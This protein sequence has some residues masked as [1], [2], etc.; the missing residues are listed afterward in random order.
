[1]KKINNFTTIDTI[2][3]KWIVSRSAAY[4]AEA[5]IKNG[6][7]IHPELVAFMTP[8]INTLPDNCVIVDAGSN[9][10][11]FS[12]PFAYL[13][14]DRGG[15]VY[16]FEVQKQLFQALCGTAVLNDL[17]NLSAFNCGLGDS[18]QTLKIPKVNY[19][20]SWDYGILSLVDQDKI[21]SYHH[22]TVDISPL[23]SFE[24][25]RLD[26]IKIDIEGMEIQAL[27]GAKQT[28]VTN[29]PWAFIEHWNVDANA[30]KGWFAG[31]DY[32]LY[33]I[34]GADILC[35]P[36]EKLEKSTLKFNEPLF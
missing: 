30:L 16:S 35:C 23:D 10:G 26:F 22:D 27:N 20:D 33:R 19:S 2:Y 8:I 18:H 4:H 31:M 24:L 5:F 29:R 6:V 28:I 17:E 13:I 21:N 32:T 11:I 12:I 1:M 25:D 34:G 7:P 14:K 36:N 3:G 9:A 15:V